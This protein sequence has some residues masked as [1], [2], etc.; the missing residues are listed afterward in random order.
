MVNAVTTAPMAIGPEL[1]H[2]ELLLEVVSSRSDCGR[3]CSLNAVGYSVGG[4]KLCRVPRRPDRLRL[5]PGEASLPVHLEIQADG[6]GESDARLVEKA[7]RQA[8]E[9][10]PVFPLVPEIPSLR[11]CYRTG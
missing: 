8:F 9:T 1:L 6:C 2:T 10:R 5:F 11:G 4:N 7:K 3:V